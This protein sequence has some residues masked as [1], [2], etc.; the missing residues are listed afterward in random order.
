MKGLKIMCKRVEHL[1]FLDSVSFLPFALC[2]MSEAF[3]L[4]VANSSSL[5]YFNTR[6]NLDYVGKIP[7]IT[8]YSVDKMSAIER[9]ESLACFEG[10]K[11]E[12]FDN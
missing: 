7:D 9:N 1:K 6:A 3:G 5:H 10:Q 4:T 2:K 8:N 11:D 12:M